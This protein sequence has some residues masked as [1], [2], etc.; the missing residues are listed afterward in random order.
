MFSTRRFRIPAGSLAQVPLLRDPQRQPRT[1]SRY[2][3][4]CSSHAFVHLPLSQVFRPH[5][6]GVFT[7]WPSRDGE[8]W[9]GERLWHPQDLGMKVSHSPHSPSRGD[10]LRRR[11][12]HSCTWLDHLGQISSRGHCAKSS[13]STLGQCVKLCFA[14]TCRHHILSCG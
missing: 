7:P 1:S 8:L 12:V 14:R 9:A 2:A 5:I 13:R 10:R 4:T 3:A 11:G 6:G